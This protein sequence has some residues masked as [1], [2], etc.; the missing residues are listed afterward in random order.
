MVVLSSQEKRVL[1]RGF[2]QDVNIIAGEN[3]WGFKSSSGMKSAGLNEVEM[4]FD[5]DPSAFLGSSL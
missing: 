4:L 3:I 5:C 2:L 1:K